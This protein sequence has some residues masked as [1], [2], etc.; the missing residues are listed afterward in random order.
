MAYKVTLDQFARRCD[1]L[2][3]DLAAAA[4]RG[5][6]SAAYRLEGLVVEALAEPGEGNR[7][8]PQ[9]TGEL[10][11]SVH[12]TAVD[13]GAVVSVDAPHAPFIEFGTRPHHPPLQ[14]LADWA[15]RKGLADTEEEALEVARRIAEIIA[16]RGTLPHHFVARAIERLRRRGIVNQEIRRELE[17]L[18]EGGA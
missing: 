11:R 10:S 14:P 7:F 13:D 18:G 15:Y 9:D 8:P 17:R 6:R 12:T 3:G 16:R 2:G 1:R 4:R 5:L